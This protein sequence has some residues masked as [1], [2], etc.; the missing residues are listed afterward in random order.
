MTEYKTESKQSLSIED[1]SPAA[2]R[3]LDA[4][5][6]YVNR[7]LKAKEAEI[8]TDGLMVYLRAQ[9]QVGCHDLYGMCSGFLASSGIEP[10]ELNRAL[11]FAGQHHIWTEISK[12]ENTDEYGITRFFY[13]AKWVG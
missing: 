9:H 2:V 11:Q 4:F 3:G 7:S 8:V 5:R 12:V 1:L 13:K 10:Q 6:A